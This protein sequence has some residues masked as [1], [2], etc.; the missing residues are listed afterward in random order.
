MSESF[1]PV[2]C[3]LMYHCCTVPNDCGRRKWRSSSGRRVSGKVSMAPGWPSGWAFIILHGPQNPSPIPQAT[4]SFCWSPQEGH[5]IMRLLFLAPSPPSPR[6]G[7]GALR[8]FHMVRFLGKR[9]DLDLVAPALEGAE[10]AERQ[11]R[12]SCREMEFVPASSE[13]MTRQLLR[14]GP[15]EK[16]PNLTDAIHRRLTSR[17]YSAVQVEKPAMLPYLPKDIRIPVILD[18]WAYGLAGPLRAL[19]HEAGIL[20]RARNLLQVVR[21]SIFDACCWPDTSCILVVSEEDRIRCQQERPGRKVLVIPNGID[22]A[23]VKPKAWG[24]ESPPVVLFTGDMGFAP[25]VD[26][27]ILLASRLFP[28]I[29]R[30]HPDAELRLVGRNPE[31]RVRR[32]SGTG[33]TVTGEVPDMTP[34]LHQATI[35]VAPHF[36][37]AGTRTKLLEA[38]AAGLPIVTT[39]VGIEGIDAAHE[40]HVLIADDPPSLIAAMNRL[41]GHASERVRLG[42]GARQLVEE[43]YDWSTCLASLEALY[44]NL[45]SIATLP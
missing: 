16:D 30:N 8:M 32:F 34:H 11:L 28:E 41:L 18:T 6:T 39:T 36:T 42:T 38:M 33:I 20:T 45:P 25:N 17:C 44:K 35:Y 43:R 10:A 15:Y 19:R 4:S 27:A 23:A 9:F 26:A 1:Q 22:C 40:R 13:G 12:G 5:L 14:L 24:R 7:G 37:G 3:R 31:S 2:W 29:R 21:F